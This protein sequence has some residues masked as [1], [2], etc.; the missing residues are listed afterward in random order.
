ML[1]MVDV[2]GGLLL[3]ENADLFGP[4]GKMLTAVRP[5]GAIVPTRNGSTS[6]SA[7]SP[8][9]YIDNGE[10]DDVDPADPDNGRDNNHG[11]SH[12]SL[13]VCRKM[14]ILISES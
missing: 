2:N 6:F 11:E 5:N 1:L 8:P 13:G 14:T 7:N 9:F 10:G 3:I 12:Y 4:D